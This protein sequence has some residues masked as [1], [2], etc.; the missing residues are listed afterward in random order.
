MANLRC[1]SYALCLIVIFS[2]GAKAQGWRGLIPL[3][4]TRADVERLLGP[5]SEPEK[6]SAD[7]ELGDSVVSVEYSSGSCRKEMKGGWNVQRDTVI[8]IR[9]GFKDKAQF[10]PSKIDKRKFKKE[11]SSH[12]PSITYY[13]NKKEGIMYEVQEGMV[14]SVEYYAVSKDLY[15]EC[16]KQP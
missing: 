11:R 12:T 13:V 8:S 3:H 15:L 10:P 14:Q 1:L 4:S 6:F 9:I 2:I 7:Y 5:S 16:P